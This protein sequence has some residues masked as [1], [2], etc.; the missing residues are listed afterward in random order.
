MIGGLETRT[1]VRI[2][3]GQFCCV[4]CKEW[5]EAETKGQDTC[6]LCEAI[7]KGELVS[8]AFMAWLE[9]REEQ[10]RLRLLVGRV[11]A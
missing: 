8:R 4:R 11:A 3:S 5:Q 1:W 2:K 7:R 9:A 6:R 10:E